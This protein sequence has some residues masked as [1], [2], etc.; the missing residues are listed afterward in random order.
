MK[1]NNSASSKELKDIDKKMFDFQN[2]T[3]GRM[4]Q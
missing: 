1:K 3:G 4:N 2:C